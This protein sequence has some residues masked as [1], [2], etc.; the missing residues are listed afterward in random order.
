MK[1]LVEFITYSEDSEL[2]KKSVHFTQ[3][4]P[5]CKVYYLH[6][7]EYRK[8]ANGEYSKLPAKYSSLTISNEDSDYNK[9]IIQM[10]AVYNDLLDFFNQIEHDT[11]IND[12]FFSNDMFSLEFSAEVLGMLKEHNLSLPI[13]FYRDNDGGRVMA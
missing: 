8:H 9:T 3:A 7:G 1:V 5:N 13:S 6:H 10:L 4:I 12:S 11:F 2:H